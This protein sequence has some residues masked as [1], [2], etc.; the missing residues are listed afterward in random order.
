MK[1]MFLGFFLI[2]L[3]YSLSII[4]GKTIEDFPVEINLAVEREKG[5]L[6]VYTDCHNLSSEKR[7]FKIII[8]IE[9]T[10]KTGKSSMLQSKKVKLLPQ[11]RSRPV[12]AFLGVKREDFYLIECQIFDEKKRL[13]FYKILTSQ[14]NS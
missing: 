4:E 3:I 2:L 7:E 8:K 13:V 9:K 11:E 6:K 10:G 1:W 14:A 12:I 5:F